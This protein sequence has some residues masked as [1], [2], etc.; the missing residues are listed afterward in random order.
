MTISDWSYSG[1][2]AGIDALRE[3]LQSIHAMVGDVQ[4]TLTALEENRPPPPPPV[5]GE[6]EARPPRLP[7][8]SSEAI[9]DYLSNTRNAAIL[10]SYIMEQI[11][12]YDGSTFPRE[13]AT[14]LLDQEYKKLV[15]WTPVAPK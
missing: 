8:S 10:A 6:E 15:F 1:N 5:S 3:K 7:F 11:E 9:R 14:I 2:A 4:A 13:F 12:E